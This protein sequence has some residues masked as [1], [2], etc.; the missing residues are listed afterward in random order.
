MRFDLR[1]TDGTIEGD[2]NVV[3]ERQGLDKDT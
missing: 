3:P 2:V 1:G